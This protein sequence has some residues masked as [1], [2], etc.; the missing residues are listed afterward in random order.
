MKKKSD[1]KRKRR[2]VSGQEKYKETRVKRRRRAQKKKKKEESGE[3]K[4]KIHEKARL[5][6]RFEN[7]SFFR[8]G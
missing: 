2:N 6:S 8:K 1:Y 5:S 3:E 7:E 4:E